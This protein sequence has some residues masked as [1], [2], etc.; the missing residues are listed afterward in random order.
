MLRDPTP[1][2]IKTPE[3]NAIWRCIKNWDIGIPEDVTEEGHQLYSEATGNH[4][5]AIIDALRKMVIEE[6]HKEHT[7]YYVDECPLCNQEEN[8]NDKI[9]S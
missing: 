5:V 8:Y 9:S 6:W 2:E 3:F 7:D 1:D 4:V